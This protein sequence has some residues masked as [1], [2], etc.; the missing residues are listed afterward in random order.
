[1]ELIQI[2]EE[3]EKKIRALELGRQVVTVRAEA[4]ATAIAKLEKSLAVMVIR[5]KNL[6]SDEIVE[7]EGEEIKGPPPTTLVE[8]I[9]KGMC[10]KEKLEAEEAEGRYKAAISGME[11]LRAELNGLQSINKHFD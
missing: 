11:S 10:W 4:K 3:I 9:A 2:K 8:R 6:G 5:L 1:V 7:F